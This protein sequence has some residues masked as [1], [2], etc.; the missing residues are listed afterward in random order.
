LF[1]V[2]KMLPRSLTREAK[3]G[4]L[5]S[6][7]HDETSKFDFLIFTDKNLLNFHSTHTPTPKRIAI[8]AP[9]ERIRNKPINTTIQ[10]TSEMTILVRFPYFHSLRPNAIGINTRTANKPPTIFGD[11]DSAPL[12]GCLSIIQPPARLITARS[13]EC[14]FQ[15]LFKTKMMVI[16]TPICPTMLA[17]TP[18]FDLGWLTNAINT[19]IAPTIIYNYP[20]P[21]C[22][23]KAA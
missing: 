13:L 11:K 17:T 1:T 21:A 7:H 15:L 10:M 8:H 14:V 3:S 23:S 5:F 22:Q 19:A 4:R 20:Q 16:I 2:S 6:P 18:K 9:R 12:E